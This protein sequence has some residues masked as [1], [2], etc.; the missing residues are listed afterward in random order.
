MRPG[1][2]EH[3][4]VHV[5][6]NMWRFMQI[7]THKVEPVWPDLK[8]VG[9]IIDQYSRLLMS[10]QQAG[11]SSIL[12]CW[13]ANVED[14]A[15]PRSSARRERCPVHTPPI[16]P[17]TFVHFRKPHSLNALQEKGIGRGGG[18]T[19]GEKCVRKRAKERKRQ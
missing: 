2:C 9:D 19:V 18:E 1:R 10:S 16:K 7:M 4:A 3:V 14:R 5:D 11:P 15:A 12:L 17:C 13:V 6:V 8:I